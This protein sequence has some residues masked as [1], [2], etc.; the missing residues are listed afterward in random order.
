MNACGTR[1]KRRCAY[2]ELLK[3][4]MRLSIITP[5]LNAERWLTECLES[6]SRQRNDAD[7]VEHVIVD[8]GSTDRTLEIARAFDLRLVQVEE[9]GLYS[10]INEGVRRAS[11]N[12][13][14]YLGGDDT[15]LPGA[16]RTVAH[17]Y[18]ARKYPWLV[19]GIR[20]TDAEGR[21]QG[22]MRAPP[23]W[24]TTPVYASLGW[25][26]IPHMSTF[27]LRDFLESVG[28]FDENYVHTGDYELF[29]RALLR[30]P[31]DRST[32]TLTTF[33]RHEHN[34]SL[35]KDRRLQT[36]LHTIRDAFAPPYPVRRL[37]YRQVLRTWLNGRS[38]GWFLVKKIPAA[39]P[40]VT[41]PSGSAATGGVSG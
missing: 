2:S 8:A 7:M 34:V 40:L 13:I 21:S 15:L 26:C 10:Q 22:D 1:W 5:T 39:R 33:R 17:W 35:S 31:F 20:W 23:S 38:P 18:G 24:M 11:G 3:T 12:V 29:A 6:V 16:A 4:G 28:E 36:E 19:G 27:F 37:L 25:S 41:R 30:S 14:G 9:P 32:A